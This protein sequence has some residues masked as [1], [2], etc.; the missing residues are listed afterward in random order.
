MAFELTAENI[1]E[2]LG[3]MT[4][5]TFYGF[6]MDINLRIA[7]FNKCPIAKIREITEH[8][9]RKRN[10]YNKATDAIN[11]IIVNDRHRAKI[12]AKEEEKRNN[13]N[14]GDYCEYE[15]PKRSC[16]MSYHPSYV[17]VIRMTKKYIFV[18]KCEKK[19]I[20]T[21]YHGNSC[22][23]TKVWEAIPEIDDDSKE[24]KMKIIDFKPCRELNEGDNKRYE[25][26]H[27]F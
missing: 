24:Y 1:N 15:S 17:K 8:V 2:T 22:Y 4:K 13:I 5:S 9:I 23:Y 20:R 6:L 18:K 26:S 27:Y 10:I 14:I 19:L 25:D 21:N 11:K 16:T 12:E 7:N 3:K